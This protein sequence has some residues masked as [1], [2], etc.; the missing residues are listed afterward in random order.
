MPSEW[1]LSLDDLVG[2]VSW[3]GGEFRVE[4]LDCC[5]GGVADI[6]VLVSISCPKGTCNR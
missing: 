4:V 3:E 2:V 5:G 6:F 1:M